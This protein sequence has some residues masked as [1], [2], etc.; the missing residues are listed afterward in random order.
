MLYICESSITVVVLKRCGEVLVVP[1]NVLQERLHT[2]H[3]PENNTRQ[4]FPYTAQ[5]QVLLAARSITLAVRALASIYELESNG[6][7][8]NTPYEIRH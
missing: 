3:P 7:C 4:N 5:F 8:L 6:P 1:A 2:T